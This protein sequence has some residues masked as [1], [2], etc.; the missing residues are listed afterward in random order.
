[1]IDQMLR[2]KPFRTFKARHRELLSQMIDEADVC[3]C[4]RRSVIVSATIKAPT[5][6]SLRPVNR[7]ANISGCGFRRNSVVRRI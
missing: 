2:N 6:T 3:R 4:I 7:A 1:M 5:R